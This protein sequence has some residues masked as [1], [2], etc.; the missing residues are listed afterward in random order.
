MKENYVGLR[1]PNF[2]TFSTTTSKLLGLLSFFFLN[3][4]KITNLFKQNSSECGFPLSILLTLICYQ[5]LILFVYY[6]KIL[7]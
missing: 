6:A 2:L 7:A 5:F 3:M 1:R 4:C